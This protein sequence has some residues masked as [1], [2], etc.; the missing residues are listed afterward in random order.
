MV[1][2]LYSCFQ[3]WRM[4]LLKR[5]ADFRKGGSGRE[6]NSSFRR[7]TMESHSLKTEVFTIKE[8][9]KILPIKFPAEGAKFNA[10]FRRVYP[11]KLCE[12]L[13]LTLRTLREKLKRLQSPPCVDA[14]QVL[15]VFLRSKMVAHDG[16]ASRCIGG[17]CCYGIRV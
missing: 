8:E 14:S 16:N 10:E 1:E 13:R 12:T 5:T 17:R 4:P 9:L 6:N 7:R 15:P 11:S 2:W 3:N